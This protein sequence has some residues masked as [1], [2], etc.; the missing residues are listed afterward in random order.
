MNPE[1]INESG[2]KRSEDA[3]TIAALKKLIASIEQRED[4]Q[5][6]S[7]SFR[8][9]LRRHKSWLTFIGALIVFL[10][11]IVKESAKED[12]KDSRDGLESALRDLDNR[13]D[14][15][16]LYHELHPLN[17]RFRTDQAGNSTS[18]DFQVQ[19][20][21]WLI[22]KDAEREAERVGEVL[23][24]LGKT[25]PEK[26]AADDRKLLADLRS[27]FK[28][29][30]EESKPALTTLE[31]YTIN[32]P[33]GIP[34][35]VTDALKEWNKHFGEWQ[36]TLAAALLKLEKLEDVAVEKAKKQKKL[37]ASRFEFWK[38]ASIALYAVGW[39]LALTGKIVGVNIA[40]EE[41]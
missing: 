33:N 34:P 26:D 39:C 8:G 29:L 24:S 15:D 11:F 25:L 2:L 22:A 28:K 10:T 30:D 12:A 7:K 36:Q 40:E 38:T 31:D 37:S 21:I 32:R 27:E 3:E 4:K 20:Q 35:A 13:R 5:K 41:E 18:S 17:V 16:R 23:T 14:L 19:L 6:P 9:F 1:E